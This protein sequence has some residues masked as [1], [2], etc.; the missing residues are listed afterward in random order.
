[1]PALLD[2]CYYTK[3]EFNQVH[4]IDWQRER[5]NLGV[6]DITRNEY[7]QNKIEKAEKDRLKITHKSRT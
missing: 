3:N 2:Y 6:F 1:M 7:F 4:F 5:N